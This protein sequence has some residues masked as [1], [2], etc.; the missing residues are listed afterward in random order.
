VERNH[1]AGNSPDRGKDR[2]DAESAVE[3]SRNEAKTKVRSEAS[4][5]ISKFIFDRLRNR[6]LLINPYGKVTN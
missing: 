2:E 6:N 4:R 3:D 1:L 5:Q